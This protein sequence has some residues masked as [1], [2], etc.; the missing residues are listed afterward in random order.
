[1]D[2]TLVQS[3][4]QQAQVGTGGAAH[5][6]ASAKTEVA[7]VKGTA[8]DCKAIWVGTGGTIYVTRNG[9]KGPALLNVPGGGY[10]SV[11]LI[12]ANNDS[13]HTDS[14]ASDM[15]AVGW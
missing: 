9:V 8:L 6:I 12:A 11:I 3:N 10:L 5:V 1:M 13:I 2:I 4:G 7:V 15:V 14:T